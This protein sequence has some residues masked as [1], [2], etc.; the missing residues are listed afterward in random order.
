MLLETSV[1]KDKDVILENLERLG[2]NHPCLESLQACFLWQPQCGFAVNTGVH[3]KPRLC[4][5]EKSHRY[6]HHSALLQHTHTLTI[7]TCALRL[8][9]AEHSSVTPPRHIKGPPPAGQVV[10]PQHASVGPGKGVLF[11]LSGLFWF[12][13]QYPIAVPSAKLW[14]CC[15]IVCLSFWSDGKPA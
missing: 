15:W 5:A 6:T 2:L 13:S 14:V 9:Y 4:L 8:V 1:K 10:P 11:A 3:I 7:N 12:Y